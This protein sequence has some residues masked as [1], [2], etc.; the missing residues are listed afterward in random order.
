[1]LGS[2]TDHVWGGVRPRGPTGTV[3][4]TYVDP[5]TGTD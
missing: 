2:F 1:M 5:G 4:G 3:S